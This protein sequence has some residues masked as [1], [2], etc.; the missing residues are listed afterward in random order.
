MSTIGEYFEHTLIRGLDEG[1]GTPG[2][3]QSMHATPRDGSLELMTGSPG[4]T[5][6]AGEACRAFRWEGDIADQAAL[7]ALSTKLGVAHAGKAWRVLSTDTFV[8]WNGSGFDNFVDAFGASGPDGASCTVS[9]GTVDTGPVHSD[10]QATITGTSPNLVLNLTVPR[11]VQGGKGDPGS[12]GPIRNAP[13]YM[14]GTHVDK[15]VPQWDSGAGKWRPRP[16]P[17]L[18]GP[19]SLYDN[20]AWDGGPGWAA[21]QSNTGASPNTVARL[22]IPAQDVDWRPVIA[23]SVYFQTMEGEQTFDTRIDAEVR[24]GSDSGQIVALGSGTPSGIDA[25]C[26]FQPFFGTRLTPDSTVGVVPAGQPVVLYVVLRRMTGGSNYSYYQGVA[27]ILC[28]AQ[29]VG[30][31]PTLA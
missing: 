2:L 3:V 15:A 22:N 23:G 7:S 13:D 14:N 31:A 18:R 8:Y 6:P 17:G 9:I 5:G 20:N 25:P 12:P 26:H 1:I 11:G 28:W 29:P 24:L 10:L 4:P 19:W 16:Y 30:F 27:Q 21:T